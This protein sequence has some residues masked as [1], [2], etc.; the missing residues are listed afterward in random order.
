[1]ADVALGLIETRGWVAALEATDAMVKSANIKLIGTKEV[2]GGF[3]SVIVRGDVGA[4][5]AAIESG[6]IAAKK[7]GALVSAHVIP[8]PH[9]DTEKIIPKADIAE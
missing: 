5:K 3:V 8:R 4:V 2:G 1:M 7:V 6:S 9:E